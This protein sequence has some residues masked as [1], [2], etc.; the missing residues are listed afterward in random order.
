LD[1][2][3]AGGGFNQMI[4]SQS[5]GTRRFDDAKDDGQPVRARRY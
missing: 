1:A 2:A 3:K 5:D 4:A